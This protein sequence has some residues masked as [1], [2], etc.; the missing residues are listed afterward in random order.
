MQPGTL[1]YIGGS[2]VIAVGGFAGALMF[3]KAHLVNNAPR[4]QAIADLI[5]QVT[6]GELKT[7]EGLAKEAKEI[8]DE[9]VRKPDE[10]AAL[11]NT[12]YL[13]IKSFVTTDQGSYYRIRPTK[14]KR[15]E[16]VLQYEIKNVGKVAA[17]DLV[18][19]GELVITTDNVMGRTVKKS[20]KK[21]IP[22]IR[23][24]ALAPGEQ[25]Y[26]NSL[27]TLTDVPVTKEHVDII[28]TMIQESGL[29]VKF[30]VDYKSERD[31]STTLRMWKIHRI[32]KKEAH[33][34]ESTEPVRIES[35]D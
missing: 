1:W 31:K 26:L 23:K 7:S 11:E 14:D 16:L 13:V 17:T 30:A 6:S 29:E 27:V 2:V 10:I 22:P 35:S 28:H 15:P 8:P 9:V 3:W 20:S 34:L 4:D 18:F 32:F 21:P 25:F 5:A 12:P 24:L 19:H 33:L